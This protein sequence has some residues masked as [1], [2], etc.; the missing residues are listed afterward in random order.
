MEADSNLFEALFQEHAAK[1]QAYCLR[2][3][4][5]EDAR[6]A[7]AEVFAVAWSK[8]RQLP[9]DEKILPW[10]YGIAARVLANQRRASRRKSAFLRRFLGVSERSLSGPEEQVLFNAETQ[11]VLDALQRLGPSDRE[12]V[13]LIAWEELTRDQ[14]AVVLGCSPEAAKKRYQRATRRLER[15]L[16]IDH[17]ERT[18][19]SRYEPEVAGNE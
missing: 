1:V 12:I 10:L 2:R 5:V 11:E 7:A 14:A 9:E 13:M 18:A 8:R 19:S 4:P 3:A 6:D 16:G 15:A 17:G